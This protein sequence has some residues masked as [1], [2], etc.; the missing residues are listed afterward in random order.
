L[1]VNSIVCSSTLETSVKRYIKRSEAAFERTTSENILLQK[2]N[3]E[4]RERKKEKHIAIKGKFIFNTQ[5]ILEVDK[6]VEAEVLKRKT[7]KK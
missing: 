6:E 7:K 1:L 4:Y 5:E 3:A 2:E